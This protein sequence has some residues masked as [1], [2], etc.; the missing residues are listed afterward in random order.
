[1]IKANFSRN[2]L[3][4]LKPLRSFTLILLLSLLLWRCISPP[5]Y[6]GYDIIPSQDFLSVKVDTSFTLS[7]Y[8]LAGDTLDSRAFTEAIVG[9]VY[10]EI[11]GKTQA[12][13]LSSVQIG[14][15]NHDFGDDPVID[16]VFF[17]LNHKETFG[18]P[19]IPMKI[20][21]HELT[22]T[23]HV[24][25][26]YNALD[27]LSDIYNPEPIG[28]INYQGDSQ[29][30]VPLSFAWA[31]KFVTADSVSLSTQADF[32]KLFNG[33]Y[34]RTDP[35]ETHNKAVHYFDWNNTNNRIV[36]YYTKTIEEDS[37]VSSS[38]TML[39]NTFCKRYNH[40]E[41]NYSAASPSLKINH[42][43]DTIIQDSV[44]YIQGM[45]GVRG[46]LKLND[47][48]SWLDS[49]PVAINRAQLIIERE[50]HAGMPADTIID[51]ITIYHKD[52]DK[53]NIIDDYDL[54][55]GAGGTYNRAKD[56]YSFNITLHL[57]HLLNGDLSTDKL[58]LEPES[59]LNANRAVLRSGNHS[60]K[61]KLII[62]YT[63][64]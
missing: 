60:G 58:Y 10:D 50:S 55:A 16:S 21:I 4:N 34:V 27:P 63:K 8:T 29:L 9:S 62:T 64:L 41:H 31:E 61:I 51:K 7:A 2:T 39:L 48:K 13:F 36:I 28:L 35:F 38:F 24:D 14:S 52:D 32:Q 6:L 18:D 57:Q 59:Y 53:I 33:I 46:M 30:K 15:V 44:F 43:N 1:M 49:M 42:I 54:N 56:H 37:I 19:S 3:P 5:D 40:F 25:S 17:I 23:L 12:S 47:L 11:F 20:Y 26:V 45:G 22:D